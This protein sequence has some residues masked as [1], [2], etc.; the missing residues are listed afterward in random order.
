MRLQEK[1]KTHRQRVIF[2]SRARFKFNFPLL[3][4]K[5]LVYSRYFFLSIYFFYT[6]LNFRRS[7]CVVFLVFVVLFRT[8]LSFCTSILFDWFL[9]QYVF[10]L[11]DF[12]HNFHEINS[13]LFFATVFI[14]A[15]EHLG[16]FGLCLFQL[17]MMWFVWIDNIILSIAL[18]VNLA[19][20]KTL[21]TF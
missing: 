16:L 13:Q 11:R 2:V 8:K 20:T 21:Q 10:F 5:F 4:W 3:H 9:F 7:L 14:V 18:S 12:N 15:V 1:K 17:E 6:H 19:S